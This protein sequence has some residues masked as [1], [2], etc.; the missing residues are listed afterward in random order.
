MKTNFKNLVVAVDL[1]KYSDLVVR[2]AKVLSQKL[3]APITYVYVFE[4]T[5]IFEPRMKFQKTNINRDYEKEIRKR[6]HLTGEDNVVI[7]FGSPTDN[8]LAVSKKV[9]NPMIIVGHRGQNA[10]SRFFLGSTAETLALNSRF[11]VWIHRGKKVISPKNIL[12]SC[13]LTAKSDRAISAVRP[14]AEKLKANAELIYVRPVLTPTLDYPS[15]VTFYDLLMKSTDAQV[16]LFKR[17][18]SSY[19][20]KECTGNAEY[21]IAKYSKGFDLLAVSPRKHKEPLLSL[22]S[23][24]A[25]LIRSV[26]KPI[27]VAP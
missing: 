6:Y 2:E 3:K 14:F 7:K 12:I 4:D 19:K 11:P 17:K 13:D 18:H 9:K 10:F 26:E 27:L 15:Y 25:K 23:V 8:I 24:T 21:Q 1:S 5:A 22:G 20:L 16:N